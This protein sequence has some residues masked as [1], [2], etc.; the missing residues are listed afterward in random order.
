MAQQRESRRQRR[1]RKA[2]QSECGGWWRKIWGGGPYQHAGIPDLL[3]CVD[4][5]FFAFE[6]KEDDGEPSELQLDEID[7]IRDAGGVASIVRTPQEA[8]A[9][10]KEKIRVG[11][12]A[13]ARARRRVRRP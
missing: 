4:G 6:V 8:V 13:V 5:Y 12:A 11:Q 9:F 1:I 3:G 7:E 2:L 10:V